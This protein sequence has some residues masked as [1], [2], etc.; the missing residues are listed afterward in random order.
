MDLKE[1]QEY[2]KRLH[3]TPKHITD[4]YIQI[5]CPICGDSQVN[6]HKARGFILQGNTFPTYFCHNECGKMSFYDFIYQQDQ[7]LA[8]ELISSK[9]KSKLKQFKTSLLYE[10]SDKKLEKEVIKDTKG[11]TLKEISVG[12]EIIIDD[13]EYGISK[14]PD[15]ALE[16]IKSRSVDIQDNWFYIYGINAILFPFYFQDNMA[17]GW[18]LRYLDYKRFTNE[19]YD[20]APKLYNYDKINN[21]PD[22]S[23]VYVFESIFNLHSVGFENSI[24][25]IG[26]SI[27]DE[28]LELIGDKE[29]VI[30]LDPDEAG[31][32]STIKL[33][34]KHK[35]WKYLVYEDW[36][37]DLDFN[38]MKRKGISS[39]Q[40]QDYILSHIH[41]GRIANFKLRCKKN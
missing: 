10:K 40:L 33:S 21:L 17:F 31:V 9:G 15:V 16:Y 14:L 3:I 13:V 22:G 19:V 32:K 26:T 2:L 5:R 20:S 12:D 4:K 34:G 25:I 38:D 29:L 8:R 35:N 39:Q 6:K 30:C 23:R 1:A 28:M 36:I 37:G 41:S 11:L 24:A 7:L 27:T 18:Q